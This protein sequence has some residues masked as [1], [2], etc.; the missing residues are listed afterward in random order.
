ML[1]PTL[2]HQV[3]TIDRR[4]LLG[5]AL[6]GLTGLA[7]A[8]CG[9]SDDAAATPPATT[10]TSSPTPT[11]TASAAPSTAVFT[12]LEE[13]YEARLG[14]YA[15]DTD[16]GR[17]IAYRADELF[18][19]CST[20]KFL[21][22]ATVLSAV[23]VP[24]LSEQISYTEEDMVDFSP[25]TEGKTSMSLGELCQAA[26]Q[27]SDNTAGNL[28]LAKVGGTQGV[29]RFVQSLGDKVTRLDR[30]EPDLNEAVPGD[31]RDTSNVQMLGLDLYMLLEG[32][33]LPEA[34]RRRLK[35]WM[36]GSNTGGERIRAAVPKGWKVAGKTGTGS[37]GTANDIALVYPKG[38]R[39]PIV[40]SIMSDK[41]GK[42]AEPDEKLLE[43]AARAALE[44]VQA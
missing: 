44:A 28:L 4:G 34:A 10:S 19:M 18:A 36:Q 31:E 9:S 17:D 11:T 16:S 7:L 20:F 43:E 30:I 2:R 32:D 33:A 40:I 29:N 22:A 15:V 38:G 21:A 41:S 26:L 1:D 25:V 27:E 3:P 5:G 23:G 12:E 37:Y 42:N 13:T 39:A 6:V 35:Q 24:G 14:L 8:A